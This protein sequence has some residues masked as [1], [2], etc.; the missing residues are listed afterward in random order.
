MPV[1]TRPARRE[2]LPA[3]LEFE[4]GIIRYERPFNP[5]LKPD[6]ISYYDVAAMIDDPAIE[7]IV[8]VDGDLV[9][10]SGYAKTIIA[11]EYI[12]PR[13]QAFLGFM[14]VRPEYRGRG[15]NKLVTDEL[16]ARAAKKGHTEVRLTV[17]SDNESAIRAYEKAG[18]SGLLLE[19]RKKIQGGAAGAE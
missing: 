8:A 13:K 11:S 15:I 12:T 16:L 17:Y 18:F 6:P 14:Y 19:M 10:G 1:S 2:D 9:V 7:V 3:L 4:Q 5:T